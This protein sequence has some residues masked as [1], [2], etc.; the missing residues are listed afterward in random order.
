MRAAASSIARGTPSRAA[1][2]CATAST[3]SSV[4]S[5]SGLAAR[6]RSRKSRTAGRRARNRPGPRGR[7][8]AAPG[9]A[10]RRRTRREVCSRA[11][12]VTRNVASG[13]AVNSRHEQRSGIQYLLEVV[14]HDQHPPVA[15]GPRDVGR[16]VALTGV[17]HPELGGDRRDDARRVQRRAREAR[18][19]RPDPNRR[20]PDVRPRSPGGSC[21][22]R[23]GPTRV[24]RRTPSRRSS[25]SRAVTS[26]SRPI[27]W[28]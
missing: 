4:T 28:V 25:S 14:Q 13:S 3:F 27:V 11:R 9:A 19:R 12:L 7:R 2:I 20:P 8:R 18:S 24:T 16:Q 17:A 23:P 10:P 5:K 6:A 22:S 26:A 15:G 21:R 1:Q